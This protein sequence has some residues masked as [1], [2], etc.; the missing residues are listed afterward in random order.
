MIKIWKE[1]GYL[2]HQTFPVLQMR[3]DS[4]VVSSDVGKLPTKLESGFDGFTADELKNWTL[5]YSIY[6]LKGII[7]KADLECWRL[8]VIACTYLCVRVI[9]LEDI[10][11]AD[12][13]LIRFCRR[14]QRIY[15]SERVTPNIHLHGHLKECIIEFGPVYSFWL[16]SFERY[17]GLLGS[18]PNNKRNIECQIMKRFLR[19]NQVW[20]VGIDTEI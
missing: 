18:L 7:P 14:F 10:K 13:F 12:I 4:A 3:V 5:I 9:T 2:D 15:T 19:D 20:K 17:N 11:L 6:A 1:K 8:F 16:F